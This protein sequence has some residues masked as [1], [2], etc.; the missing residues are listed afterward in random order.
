M[1]SISSADRKRLQAILDLGHDIEH[2]HSSDFEGLRRLILECSNADLPDLSRL[3]IHANS[4]QNESPICHLSAILI[5]FERVAGRTLDDSHI[6]VSE[7]D[8]E[9]VSRTHSKSISLI[10]DNIR[11]AFNV[12]ALFRT[13]ECFGVEKIFLSGYTPTPET[14]AVARTEMGT[15]K[16]V[17][18]QKSNRLSD[19]I[20]DLKTR[21]YKIIALETAPE[22]Q[23][24]D[25]FHWP[26]KVALVVGNERFGLDPAQLK[27]ADHIVQIPLYG[28]KNSLNVG[29]AAALA[30]KA[31]VDSSERLK[32]IGNIRTDMKYP[33]DASR[34]G[35]HQAMR[36]VR[37]RIELKPGHN[38]EQ[39]LSDL[40]GIDRIWIISNFNQVTGWSPMV[41]PPRGKQKRGVFATRAPHRPNPI[42][43]TCARLLNIQGRTLEIAE[44]DLLDQTPVYDIKPYIAYADS[45]PEAR[46]G[47]IDSLNSD[48]FELEWSPSSL[49]KLEWL[50]SQMPQL[51]SALKT[52]LMDSPLDTVRKRVKLES[53]HY[54]VLSYRTWR[55]KFEVDAK[56]VRV[57]DIYSGYSR[58]ELSTGTDPYADKE[59][60][61]QFLNAFSK[62]I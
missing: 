11:S 10:A 31:C 3:S 29:I 27:L 38:F 62:L 19:A 36:E 50:K 30:L 37:G 33:A 14:E 20:Q 18:W 59:L 43:L 26:D 56:Q 2:G 60:H 48:H 34:Q 6:L 1:K 51:E 13:A 22:A 40:V 12:G 39:A 52:Q 35:T 9:S 46:S 23:S 15:A 28:R 53:D 8:A 49:E 61:R 4:L 55:I 16:M 25:E 32:P 58:D 45:F 42:G 47:W 21:G 24:V 54:A 17:E 5:A 44:F 57:L 7:D 41:Q